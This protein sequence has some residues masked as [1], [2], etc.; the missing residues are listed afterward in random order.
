MD[1][2]R[3]EFEEIKGRVDHLEKLVALIGSKV[4]FK[5]QTGGGPEKEPSH[6]LSTL[7]DVTDPQLDWGRTCEYPHCIKLASDGHY[8]FKHKP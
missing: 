8:C 2:T 3:E 1:V 7:G 6:Y 5:P 4:V